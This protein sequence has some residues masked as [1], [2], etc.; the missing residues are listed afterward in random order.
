MAL[1]LLESEF[2][3]DVLKET[4]SQCQEPSGSILGNHD[5][6]HIFNYFT[7]PKSFTFDSQRSYFGLSE[8][9]FPGN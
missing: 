2:S 9:T 3:V 5:I 6:M 7:F 1:R 8:L 4:N